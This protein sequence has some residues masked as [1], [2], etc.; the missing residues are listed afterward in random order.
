MKIGRGGGSV[1]ILCP[2]PVGTTF[3]QPNDENR[4]LDRT[5]QRNSEATLLD[6][7]VTNT[8]F[9]HVIL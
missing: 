5:K 3:S 8:T 9:D 1:R 2:G 7:D 4:F 6:T